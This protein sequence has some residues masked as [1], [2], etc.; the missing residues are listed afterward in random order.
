MSASAFGFGNFGLCGRT[1]QAAALEKQH[2]KRERQAVLSVFR[3]IKK[4]KKEEPMCGAAAPT[5]FG[6]SNS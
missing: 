2:L 5:P 1:H 6:S 3:R 4:D